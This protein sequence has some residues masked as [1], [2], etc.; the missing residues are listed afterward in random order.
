MPENKKQH[1]VPQFLLKNFHNSQ[2]NKAIS[3]YNIPNNLCVQSTSISKQACRDYFYSEDTDVEK[4]LSIAESDANGIIKKIIQSV[5]IP[6]VEDNEYPKLLNFITLQLYR[7]KYIMDDVQ[8]Y[9]EQIAKIKKDMIE[10]HYPEKHLERYQIKVNINKVKI[11]FRFSLSSPLLSDLMM[12]IL[13]NKTT[14]PFV[15]SDNPVIVHNPLL[16]EKFNGNTEGICQ[17]GTCMFLPI[18]PKLCLLLYDSYYY[19]IRNDNKVVVLNQEKD[20][21]SLNILQC[22]NADINIFTNDTKYLPEVERI[23]LEH[24]T[25]KLHKNHENIVIPQTLESIDGETINDTY[26]TKNMKH[27]KYVEL[28]FIKKKRLLSDKRYSIGDCIRNPALVDSVKDDINWIMENIRTGV[29]QSKYHRLE[30][31]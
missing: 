22:L 19:G 18:S 25:Y 20:V 4:I 7:T 24:E 16:F 12:L 8:A 28:S 23:Y 15:I 9:H 1:Y 21:F 5:S 30:F 14:K 17:I 26:V 27:T 29:I 3:M 2:S 31:L 13:V 6:G 11:L 10:S